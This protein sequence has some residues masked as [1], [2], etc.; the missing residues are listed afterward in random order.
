MVGSKTASLSLPLSVS[1]TVLVQHAT[2]SDRSGH[3]YQAIG[4]GEKPEGRRYDGHPERYD[5]SGKYVSLL[6]LR[7]GLT[8]HFLS[9][10]HLLLV[11][12]QT[13]LLTLPQVGAMLAVERQLHLF[14]LNFFVVRWPL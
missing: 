4:G 8:Y 3:Q 14:C 12:Q 9:L 5:E 13:R 6:S 7:V 11:W 10:C 2:V 1:W